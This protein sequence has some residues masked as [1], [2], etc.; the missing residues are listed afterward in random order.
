MTVDGQA[1]FGGG[2]PGV[3]NVDQGAVSFMQGGPV[4]GSSDVHIGG[5]G[6]VTRS[7]RS[8][9]VSF[10]GQGIVHHGAV[11]VFMA[12]TGDPTRRPGLEDVTTA[13][14]GEG[15]VANADGQHVRLAE[16]REPPI[17]TSTEVQEGARGK[18]LKRNVT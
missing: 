12:P 1:T 5:G 17:S 4:M 3:V 9:E 10:L 18:P 11:D 16:S 2:G 7:P 13:P 6:D 8:D 14:T 15:V